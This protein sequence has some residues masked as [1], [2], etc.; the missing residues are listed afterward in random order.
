MRFDMR[1][2]SLKARMTSVSALLRRGRSDQ[3]GVAAIEFA[4]IGPIMVMMLIG[5]VELS[6]AIT[7]DRRVTQ[8]ASSTADLVAREKTITTA[9]LDNIMNIARALMQP[10]DPNLL[11][12]TLVNVG[13]NINNAATTKVCWSYNYQGGASSYTKLQTYALPAGVIDK[14]GSVMVAEVKYFYTPLIFSHFITT[15]MTTSATA[16]QDK[17][18]LK[19]RV[20]SMIQKDSE[21]ICVV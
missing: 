5:T 10:Y 20:S 9:Q 14:G 12:I 15:A 3:R 18:F 4:M 1:F 16:L 21:A 13:A 8:I 6:Q 19:P 7:I 17:F 2:P 11:R